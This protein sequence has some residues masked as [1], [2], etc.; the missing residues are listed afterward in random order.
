VLT[1]R[2]QTPDDAELAANPRARSAKLRAG[3]RTDAAPRA[4][5]IA[6]L[7]PHLPSLADV[8]RGQP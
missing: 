3:E 8:V 5:L 6:P 7:L 4:T 1:R 2:P